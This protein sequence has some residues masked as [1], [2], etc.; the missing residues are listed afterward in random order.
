MGFPHLSARGW[1]RRY[2]Q[3]EEDILLAAT[4]PAG[5]VIARHRRRKR[6]GLAENPLALLQMGLIYVEPGRPQMASPIRWLRGSRC[7]E[8]FCPQWRLNGRETVA[9][10]AGGPHP[11]A[12]A[13]GAGKVLSLRGPPQRRP[14]IEEAGAGLAQPFRQRARGS[15]FN[16]TSGSEGACEKNQTPPT[17]DAAL[18]RDALRLRVGGAWRKVPAGALQWRAKGCFARL[19]PDS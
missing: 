15:G 16:P 9:L 14:G 17:W 4:K 2:L 11:S 12:R 19:A 10:V 18:L 8:T 5:W 6:V 3:P 13:H 7:G 1:A